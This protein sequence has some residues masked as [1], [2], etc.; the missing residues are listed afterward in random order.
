M[1]VAFKSL[2]SIIMYNCFFQFG[3][4]ITESTAMARSKEKGECSANSREMSTFIRFITFKTLYASPTLIDAIA[5]I[6]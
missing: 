4:I 5:Q 3:N 2:Y 6:H 1:S